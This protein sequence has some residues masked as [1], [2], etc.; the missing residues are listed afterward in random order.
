VFAKFILFLG[1]LSFHSAVAA[2]DCRDAISRRVLVEGQATTSPQ[3]FEAFQKAYDLFPAPL[4]SFMCT[5]G[6]FNLLSDMQS[7]ANAAMK[8]RKG[9]WDQG[10][11]QDRWAT[12]K[13]QLSFGVPN[14]ETYQNRDDL[15]RVQIRLSGQE[16]GFLY[17][18]L[19]HELGHNINRDRNFL[20]RWRKT[21]HS[22][23]NAVIQS[24]KFCRYWCGTKEALDPSEIPAI[25]GNLYGQSVLPTTYGA[26]DEEED[27]ADSFAIYVVLLSG[28]S[29]EVLLPDGSVFS[30]R[31]LYNSPRFAENLALLKEAYALLPDQS[32]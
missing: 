13:E 4:K 25:Y 14:D 12:W 22:P 3:Y 18:M 16:P 24:K 15:P 1:L 7:S 2:T 10:L 26:A 19:A 32:Q 8:F 21:Y 30:L 28:G 27:F 9:F 17:F 5:F 20:D 31:D 23:L 6:Q 11:S 29:Y